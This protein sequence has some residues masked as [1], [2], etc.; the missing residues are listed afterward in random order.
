MTTYKTAPAG[1]TVEVANGTIFEVDRFGTDE[2]DLNQSGSTM[3]PVKMVSVA[4]VP[5]LSRNL[6]CTC[7]PVKQWGKSLVYYKTKA[8]LKF[9]GEESLVF[10][11][12]PHKGLFSVTSVKRTPSQGAALAV[13]TK[14]AEAIRVET[15][16]LCGG[17]ADV[18]R[19]SSQG[20][21]LALAA[22]MAEAMRTA[23]GQW[24]SCADVRRG[25]R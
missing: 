19:S 7:K 23:T 21:A 24:R 9:Q 8:I 13:A 17:C 16:G 11:F 14:T 3:K 22:K 12:W 20:A 5:R 18:R 4:Y 6:L 25:P 10:N 1:T 2:V 15:M